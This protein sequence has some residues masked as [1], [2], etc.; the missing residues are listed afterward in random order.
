[1]NCPENARVNRSQKSDYYNLMSYTEAG[2]TKARCQHCWCLFVEVSQ[3]IHAGDS[4]QMRRE[5]KV[6]QTSFLALGT[7]IS[8]Y[9]SFVL[10]PPHSRLYFFCVRK[11]MGNTSADPLDQ[12]L[13]R[14]S[15]GL[16]KLIST[17]WPKG[18]ITTVP[19][20][21]SVLDITPNYLIARLQ[22]RSFGEC[23]EPFHC[24]CFQ[25]N[26]DLEW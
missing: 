4:L 14:N 19:P 7:D 24:N 9:C 11:E 10:F 3:K 15:I 23:S 6:S 2:L 8:P 5:C 18:C 12:S 25:V 1:M 17:G 22:L 21:T 20:P 13:A 16:K 26:F